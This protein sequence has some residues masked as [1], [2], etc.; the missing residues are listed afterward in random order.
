MIDVTANKL[1]ANSGKA[2]IH[3]ENLSKIFPAWTR[4]RFICGRAKPYIVR[5]ALFGRR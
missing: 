2:M 4:R 5:A 1:N 3:L